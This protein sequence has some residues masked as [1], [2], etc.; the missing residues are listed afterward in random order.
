MTNRTMKLVRYAIVSE[1]SHGEVLFAKWD[2][3][4]KNISKI[5]EYSPLSAAHFVSV[6]N[7]RQEM[8]EC[9]W[10]KNPRIVQIDVTVKNLKEVR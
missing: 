10:M 5:G 2:R 3:N 6:N 9:T 1:T 4:W 8:A 7:A